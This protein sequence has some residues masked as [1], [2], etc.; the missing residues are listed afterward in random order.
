MFN[1]RHDL[2]RKLKDQMVVEYFK[3]ATKFQNNHIFTTKTKTKSRQI[4][5]AVKVIWRIYRIYFYI[6]HKKKSR[7]FPLDFVA[8]KNTQL[9]DKG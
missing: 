2:C 3:P 1:M 4:I 6:V 8:K 7:L 5:L 9:I